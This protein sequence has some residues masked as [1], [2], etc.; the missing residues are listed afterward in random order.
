MEIII[1]K[2]YINLQFSSSNNNYS[3]ASGEGIK[4]AD[5]IELKN[6]PKQKPALVS[7]PY[8]FKASIGIVSVND[9]PNIVF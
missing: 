9:F 1:G 7:I 4:N 5:N 6:I 8:N 2:E 3:P